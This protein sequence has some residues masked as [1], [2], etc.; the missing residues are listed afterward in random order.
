MGAL[1]GQ[2]PIPEYEPG[3]LP[4]GWP[5]SR[6]G[7]CGALAVGGP[8]EL[9]VGYNRG[10]ADV[11]ENHRANPM[12]EITLGHEWFK[13][14]GTTGP[15][16]KYHARGADGDGVCRA[17]LDYD[18]EANFFGPAANAN[19]FD[20]C[21]QCVAIL[22]H[23]GHLHTD[24]TK[25]LKAVRNSRLEQLRRQIARLQDEEAKLAALPADPSER[26]KDGEPCVVWF[27]KRFH[28]GGTVYTYAAVRAGDGLW[29]TT[30]PESPKGYAWERLIEWVNQVE[31][32][33]V[34]LTTDVTPL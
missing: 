25:P 24:R 16:S 21:K 14:V 15:F 2:F 5:P 34:W 22:T 27:E 4:L 3:E 7:R 17:A 33:Q 8:C 1:A 9:A 11:P 6:H 19:R 29:Y 13:M 23:P 31:P 20:R 32:T 28:R 12:N 30:G 10:Q 26:V 18:R